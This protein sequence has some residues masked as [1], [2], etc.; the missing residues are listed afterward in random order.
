MDVLVYCAL[1]IIFC[2]ADRAIGGGFRRSITVALMLIGAIGLGIGGYGFAGLLIAAWLI[3]RTVPWSVGGTITPRGPRQ[4]AQAFLRHASPA[5][6]GVGG[7][8]W[9]G[10][11]PQSAIP[12]VIYG[13]L[14][15]GLAVA[16]AAHIDS[17]DSVDGI[18]ENNNLEIVRGAAYGLA[19]VWALM[20]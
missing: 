14:A 13:A 1:P 7:N 12:L 4:I 17:G 5:V 3:Y 2:A 10:V 20:I 16:Y 9:F 11:Q 18:E 6:A 15:T 8:V 19:C